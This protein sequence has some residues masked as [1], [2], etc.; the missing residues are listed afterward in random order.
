MSGLAEDPCHQ[1]ERVAVADQVARREDV[2][3][4]AGGGV[5]RNLDLLDVLTSVC[6]KEQRA[7][8]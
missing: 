5:R 8:K 3:D 6:R 4:L 7:K 2:R 1:H